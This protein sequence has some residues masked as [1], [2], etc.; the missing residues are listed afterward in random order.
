MAEWYKS[1]S[2]LELVYFYIAIAATILLIVQI[3]M[4]I[5]SFAGEVDLDGDGIPDGADFDADNGLCIFT[6]KGTIAF[7]AVGGWSGLA[8]F[9]AF[10]DIIWLG[11]IISIAAGSCAML[12]V[13]L[14]LKGIN[15][16]QC[17]GNVDY[18]KLDGKEASVYVAVKPSR[19]GKGKITLV[20]QGRYMELDALT[21]EDE[22]LKYGDTVSIIRMEGDAAVVKKIIKE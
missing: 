14:V 2:A 17:E 1:L 4:M 20:A 11:I 13:A 16:L 10:P 7:F 6:V 5:F 15:K 21:E 3:A 8:I 19:T 18:S 9:S 22:E 12:T